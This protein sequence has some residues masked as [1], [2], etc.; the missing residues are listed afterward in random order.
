MRDAAPAGCQPG[1]MPIAPTILDAADTSATR[2]ECFAEKASLLPLGFSFPRVTRSGRVDIDRLRAGSPK[3]VEVSSRMG[4]WGERRG[5]L[6]QEARMA[7][8]DISTFDG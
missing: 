2:Y 3:F 7:D 6:G 1:W 4:T 5:R 8:A